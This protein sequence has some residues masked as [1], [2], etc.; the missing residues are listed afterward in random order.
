MKTYVIL[1]QYLAEVIIM[2][3]VSDKLVKKI[4]Q[5]FIFDTSFFENPA[6]YE[7][8]RKNMVKSDRSQ[9]TI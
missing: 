5:H 4:K 3:Y 6:V 8:M 1:W 7:I 9:M 2:R